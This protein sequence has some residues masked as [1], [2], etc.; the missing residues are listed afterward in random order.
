MRSH[1]VN[2][3]ACQH[4]PPFM[5]FLSVSSTLRFKLNLSSICSVPQ[6]KCPCHWKQKQ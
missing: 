1:S 3:L 2:S 6:G 4:S 5:K